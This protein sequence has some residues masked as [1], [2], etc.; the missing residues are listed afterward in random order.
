MRRVINGPCSGFSTPQIQG[1]WPFSLSN[2]CHSHR[3]VMVVQTRLPKKVN[4]LLTYYIVSEIVNLVL[5]VFS[6]ALS[7]SHKNEK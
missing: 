5:L 1:I 2:P 7:T 3:R 4:L 6:H